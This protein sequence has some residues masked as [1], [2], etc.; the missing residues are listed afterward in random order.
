MIR[1]GL[2]VPDF[3]A[4][5]QSL[6]SVNASAKGSKDGIENFIMEFGKDL[7]FL[8]PILMELIEPLPKDF[9]VQT[10]PHAKEI[11]ENLR[12]DHVLAL[13]TAGSP[14]FQMEK[15]KKA[16]IDRSIFSNISTP[17]NSSK[18]PY[19]ERLIQ[20]FSVSPQEAFVCGDRVEKDLKPAHELGMQTVHM[21]FGRGLLDKTDDWV[22]HQI[23][24]LSELKRIIQT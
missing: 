13:V 14:R 16:G 6:L 20:E 15:L 17:E 10:T 18:K 12:K 2:H 22:Q 9:I 1:K 7:T 3:D 11:L 8:E 21:R 19:Y 5:Y 24:R 4:A 23:H